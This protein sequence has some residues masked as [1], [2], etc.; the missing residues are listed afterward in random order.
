MEYVAAPETAHKDIAAFVDFIANG[1]V[2][3]QEDLFRL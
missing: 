1:V 3:T 2:F